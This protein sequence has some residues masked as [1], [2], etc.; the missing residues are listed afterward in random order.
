MVPR[1]MRSGWARRPL[2]IVALAVSLLLAG[3][4]VTSSWTL[5][6]HQVVERDFAGR[7]AA[8]DVLA[9]IP[10]GPSS[11]LR[12]V[13]DAAGQRPI[14]LNSSSVRLADQPGTTMLF[15]ETDWSETSYGY[16][17]TAGRWPTRPGEVVLTDAVDQNGEQQ[18][19]SLLSGEVHVQVVGRV[20]DAYGNEA[21]MLAAPGT[22]ASLPQSIA[23]AR[24]D[25]TAQ[26]SVVTNKSDAKRLAADLKGRD[27]PTQTLWAARSTAES[28]WVSESPFAFVIPAVLVPMAVVALS[29]SSGRRRQ[30][31]LV[32]RIV[33]IGGQPRMAVT[34]VRLTLG[35]VVLL[36]V[37]TGIALGS[38][39]GLGLT[40]LASRWNDHDPGPFPGLLWP[41]SLLSLSAVVG[42][43]VSTRRLI[44]VRDHR[45]RRTWSLPRGIRLWAALIAGCVTVVG[46]VRATDAILAML[47]GGCLLA[48]LALV[49]PEVVATTTRWLDNR[50]PHRRLGSR[51]L[52]GD[53][54]TSA[55]IVLT[56]IVLALPL[57]TMVLL[58]ASGSSAR[59]NALAAVGPHQLLVADV[60]GLG[61]PAPRAVER[62]VATTMADQRDV[63]S[64]RLF[65]TVDAWYQVP[66][67]NA[68]VL[69][70]D[71][72]TDVERVWGRPLTVAQRRTLESGG[73][74]VWQP[75]SAVLVDNRQPNP[76]IATTLY[77]PEEEWASHTGA[78][79]LRRFGEQHGIT[80]TRGGT[81]YSNVTDPAADAAF[82]ALRKGHLDQSGIERYHP[83]KELIPP[84]ALVASATLLT[85]LMISIAAASSHA[86]TAALRRQLGQL[87]S[88]GAGAEV[89][90]KVQFVM[91]AFITGLAAL[92]AA[93]VTSIATLSLLISHDSAQVNPPWL[94]L[95]ATTG[96]LVLAQIGVS[97]IA[98]RRLRPD[99][100]RVR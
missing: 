34:G 45:P 74:L 22:W 91:Q 89:I 30:Q 26:A 6:A 2:V 79:M 99:D 49:M 11:R 42:L 56:T 7:D 36:G 58:T 60:G 75:D 14:R 82:A 61:V 43:L 73:A 24:R 41:T 4:I 15:A 16:R 81:L 18:V 23:S 27:I 53:R 88:L 83:P 92:G 21:A 40:P 64:T 52:A 66:V 38:V 54:G 94:T 8:V 76:A 96:A 9:P 51:L 12:A 62:S 80:F 69:A 85:I 25:L 3:F 68:S 31:I 50:S 57:T 87:I 63:A 78:V 71:S 46:A 72:P 98:L 17:L 39:L 95:L 70:V 1:L 33:T 86:R 28:N 19:L 48:T 59:S 93:L 100:Q 65:I 10:P 35:A 77:T 37:A 97:L 20:D 67:G 13:E 55:E 90:R 29:V 44:N 84:V 47:V 32:D 5:S